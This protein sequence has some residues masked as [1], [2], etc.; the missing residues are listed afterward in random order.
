MESIAVEKEDLAFEL[1]LIAEEAK[2]REYLSN[3]AKWVRERLDERPWSKQIEIMDSVRDN[4]HTAVPSCF[5]SG[6][7]WTAARLTA[8]WIDVH[9]PGTAFVVTTATTGRQVRAILWRELHRA[10]SK[11]NLPGRLNQ[12]EW[13]LPEGKEG[14]EQI[15][16]FGSKPADMD[17]DAFTGIHDRYVLVIGDEASG[18]PKSL[19]EAADALIVN[20]DSRYLLIGN[21][22][23]ASAEF[24]KICEPGSGW[25]VI[26]IKAWDCPN[27]TG[28]DVSEVVKQNTISRI[29]VEEKRKRWGEDNPMW[30]AKVEAEFPSTIINGLI[31]IV[32]INAAIDRDLPA[33]GINVLGVDVGAGGDR[34]VVAHRHGGRIRIIRRNQTVDTMESCGN[35]IADLKKTRA[36]V[37]KVDYIGIGRGLVDR[38]KEQGY[39]MHGIVVSQSPLDE[40]G[41][42]KKLRKRKKNQTV[43]EE[44]DEGFLNVRAQAFWAM[45]EAFLAGEVDLDPEDEDL[46]ADLVGIRYKRTSSGKIQIIEKEALRKDLGH[47]PDDGDSAMLTYAIVPQKRQSPGAIW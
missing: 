5:G 19:I 43:E 44:N 23:D 30:R 14:K 8:W 18:L 38:G 13:W 40:E 46:H 29:W 28:E 20:E 9:P 3:P 10:H 17:D 35:V 11:G 31:P 24:A 37:A 27:F 26:R 22:T 33:E 34:N 42:P 32:A 47:S 39:P 25:H 2:R 21:P 1:S 45:R 16:A 15:V 36:T 6:K 4:R 12:T 41:L 7:S